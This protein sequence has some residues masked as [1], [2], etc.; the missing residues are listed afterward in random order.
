MS[1]ER[2]HQGKGSGPD[3]CPKCGSREV[4]HVLYGEPRLDLHIEPWETLGGC[5]S[6]D[7]NRECHTCGYLWYSAA[8]DN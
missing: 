3:A 6:G 8:M 7:T 2:Q 4:S 5:I 1:S